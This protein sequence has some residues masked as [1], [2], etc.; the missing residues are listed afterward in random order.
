MCANPSANPRDTPFVAHLTLPQ[1]GSMCAIMLTS[2]LTL[3]VGS[4]QNLSFVLV[5]LHNETGI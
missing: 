5:C 3:S 4:S 1:G 2:H